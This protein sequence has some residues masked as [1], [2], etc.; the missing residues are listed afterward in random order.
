MLFLQAAPAETTGYM[1]AGYV[2]IFG[3]IGLY[4]ASLYLRK[5]NLNQD[6]ELLQ[7]QGMAE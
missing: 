1:I 4:I 2:I 7:E 3:M 5:R 6:L